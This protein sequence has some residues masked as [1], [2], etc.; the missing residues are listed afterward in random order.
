M[1]FVQHRTIVDMRPMFVIGE[2][3]QYIIDYIWATSS[4]L[5]PETKKEDLKITDKE[6]CTLD[7]GGVLFL[8]IPFQDFSVRGEIFSVQPNRC[9]FILKLLKR[10]HERVPGYMRFLIWNYFV[11]LPKETLIDLRLKIEEISKSDQALHAAI[12]VNQTKEDLEAKRICVFRNTPREG[13]YAR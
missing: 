9:E 10:A 1:K 6:K 2:D 3:T 13:P 7:P 11:I 12:D 4:S 5:R 8:K